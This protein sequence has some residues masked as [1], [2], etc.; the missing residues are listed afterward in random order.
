MALSLLTAAGIARIAESDAAGK[1]PACIQQT[2]EW[3]SIPTLLSD[4][5]QLFVDAYGWGTSQLDHGLLTE[6][7]ADLGESLGLSMSFVTLDPAAREAL[8]A[9]SPAWSLIDPTA[10]SLAIFEGSEGEAGIRIYGLP[11]VGARKPGVAILPYVTGTIP[12]PIQV[13]ENLTFAYF[14]GLNLGNGVAVVVRP[15]EPIELLSGLTGTPAAGGDVRAE[16]TYTGSASER[17][18]LLGSS[19]GTRLQ[20]TAVSV[21]AGATTGPTRDLFIE[22][23]LIGGQLIIDGGEGNSFLGALLGDATRTIDL[24]PAIGWSTERGAFMPGGAALGLTLP[25]NV[26]IGPITIDDVLIDIVPDGDRIDIDL[27][28]ALTAAI[29]PFG[30]LVDKIGVTGG[31]R[32]P[33]SGGN[34]GPIDADVRFLP[35]TL[36]VFGLET[37]AISGGGFV[38][39]DPDTG[40][41]AGGLALDVFGVGISAIVVV[42]TE[43]PGDRRLGALR[44]PRRHLPDADPDR[45]RLHAHRR[46]RPARPQP[47]DRRR[48]ARR[49]PRDGAADAILFPDDI[50]R[51][52]DGAGR[53]R[54]VVPDPGGHD[55]RRAGRGDRL[56][57]PD[58]DLGAA[59]GDRRDPRPDHHAARQRRGAAA[60]EGRGGAD[61]PHGRDRRSRRPRLDVI[62][63][64]SLHD[65]NL[66]GVFELSGDMGFY[67]CLAGQPLFV[68]S[69]GGY[70]PQF[71]PPGALPS[72]LLDLRRICASIPLGDD[73][74]VTLTSYVAVTSNTFQFGGRVED[75]RH[76]RG[77]AHHLHGGGLVQ[78]QRPARPEAV[79]DHGTG[80][81]R[82]LDLGGR[83]GAARRRP[84]D[85]DRGPAAVVRDRQ[86]RVHLLRARR[87]LRVRRSARSLAASR[88]SCTPSPTTSSPALRGRPA[89]EAVERRRL[90]GGRRRHR[91]RAARGAV[92]ASRPGGRGPPVGRAAQPDDDRLRRVHPGSGPDRRTARDAR[93]HAGR[94]RRSGST[95]GSRRPSSTGST[96]RPGSRRPPTS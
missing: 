1:R 85:A 69:I 61:V 80:H 67:A 4:P 70:H 58:A 73:V 28:A 81:G 30:V 29:G 96:T 26:T 92:G 83:Q 8:E 19:E 42:D 9:G 82:R 86:R 95:T 13:T 22:F 55:D 51:R 84:R 93:R 44:E 2:I 90:V 60:D 54:P 38:D 74:D 79:H 88:A 40:R 12:N 49:R 24:S 62:V 37:E 65:S 77:A 25:L 91:R 43:I 89:V 10:L 18:L 3:Q 76:R 50:E 27:G 48:R 34:L 7:L 87:R 16:L 39:I 57:Q 33:G 14:T 20:A 46:R 36:L 68:L 56:G 5:R 53:P 64:A 11:P 75:R 72:W 94:R 52:D 17:L 45:L 41:Y 31:F 78:P 21:T 71:D 66:L 63:A 35:P 47:H 6:L 23:Q 59:R 15:G 32:F